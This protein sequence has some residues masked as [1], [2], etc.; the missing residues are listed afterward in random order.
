M[1]ETIISPGVLTREQDNTFLPPAGVLVAGA[2]FVG[3]TVK[4]PVEDPTVVSS[5]TEYKAI[6]GSNFYSG[7]TAEEYLTSIAVKNYFSQGGTSALITRVVSGSFTPAN[8]TLVLRSGSASET[9]F[10]L[11]T[12]SE[13]IIMNGVTSSV[14]TSSDEYSDGSLRSGSA[15]N[16]RWEVTNVNENKGT[17]TL[18]IRRGDDTL[19]DKTVL[20]TYTNL[21]LDPESPNYIARAIGNQYRALQGSGADVYLQPIGEYVN[22]SKYVRVVSVDKPTP[23]YLATDG[24]SINLIPGTSNSY[25]QYL[26][27]PASGSFYGATGTLVQAGVQA[28][29]FD[30]ISATNAQG[31]RI[32]D[33][34]NAINLLANKDEYIFNVISAPGL[35]LTDHNSTVSSLITLAENRGDCLAVVDTTGYNGSI[36]DVESAADAVDSSYAATYWP[37]VQTISETGKAVWVPAGTL[38]PGVYAFTD[39]SAA[40]WIAPAGLT[41]GGLGTVTQAARKVTQAQRDTLYTANVNPIASFPGFGVVVYGQKTLQKKASALDRVNVR[42][43]LIELKNQLANVAK[44]VVFEQNTE[45]TR[46]RFLSRVNP[47]LKSVVER[48]GLYAYEVIMDESNNTADV[49]DRN[50]LVGQVRIQP[51]RTIEYIVLDFVLDP[52]GATFGA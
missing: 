24:T 40:P 5:Y 30:Q 45:A 33:Y 49:I 3:P 48:Q 9:S 47:Y 22:K 25:A 15:D 11:A 46:D 7:S 39:R 1:A 27:K 35:N 26:P 29:Y 43:L 44:T 20:E 37:W 13:G 52:T 10:T 12:I 19:K 34:T 18:L 38:I 14:Y 31:L 32:G 42:R 36:G 23:R 51:T 28:L 2:A 4:G 16:L 17:F 50:M 41:R 8:S 6:F 21:S